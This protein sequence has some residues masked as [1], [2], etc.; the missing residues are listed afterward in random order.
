MKNVMK[1]FVFIMATVLLLSG[2]T[3]GNVI[4][5]TVDES[6][7]DSISDK[8]TDE[9]TTAWE[10]Q[11]DGNTKDEAKNMWVF[12]REN[13]VSVR[14]VS[15]DIEGDNEE[16][17][18][19]Q[20][21]DPHLNYINEKDREENNSLVISSARD[22]W[23]RD[24]ASLSKL[25][26]CLEYGKASD[27][28]VITG[29]IFS[30][31]SWGNLELVKKYIFDPYPTVM[32]CLG[33]HDP[34]RS[35]NGA[36]DESATVEER[37]QILADNWIHDIYYYSKV[38]NEKVMVVT[39]DN[40]SANG[41]GA[42]TAEQ[43]TKLENDLATAREKGYIVLLFYHIPIST[44]NAK[45][46]NTKATTIGDKNNST[47]NFYSNGINQYSPGASGEMYKLITSNAD[48]IKGCFSGHKHCDF[49]TEIN[50][51]NADGTETVIPQYIL[52]GA[53]YGANVLKITVK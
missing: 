46:Y 14:N 37:M 52:I 27:Q 22:C 30:Y 39:L 24:A 16:I 29:D 40:G 15:I 9:A 33:N 23:L 19:I 44:G 45:Y 32:A 49:Y 10:R 12:T 41:Y 53:A 47:A 25:Q 35:W 1:A 4:E 28:I 7:I 18:I 17:E 6:V 20:I 8:V 51:K 2:C 3:T 21:T 11:T 34:L 38:I 48:I 26:K 13:G 50:A 5:E 43:V 31:L 42:F 36:A